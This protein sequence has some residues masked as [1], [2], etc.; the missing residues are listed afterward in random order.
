MRLI[1]TTNAKK[2]LVWSSQRKSTLQCETSVNS[3]WL[4]LLSSKTR[5]GLL[6]RFPYGIV[7]QPKSDAIII[8]AVMQLNRKPGYWS[9]RTT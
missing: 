8:I 6:K 1:I 9:K 3:H 4:G 7:Y 2:V 5:R